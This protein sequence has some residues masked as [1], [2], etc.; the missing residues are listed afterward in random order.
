M[1][2]VQLRPG[3]RTVAFVAYDGVQP[4][5]LDG[6]ERELAKRIF[7]GVEHV[8]AQQRST[9][10]AVCGGRGGKTYTL[11]SLRLVHG[12]LT[13]DLS[14]V[15]PGQ[16]ARAL[17][18]APNDRLRQ[19]SVNYA[20]G[21]MRISPWAQ[22]LVLPKGATPESTVAG[23]AVRRPEG[24]VVTFEAGVASAGGY[25]GRGTSLTDVLFDEFAFFRDSGSV[26]N[27]AVIFRAAAPR[28]LPGG[29]A[30]ATT[31]PWAK[32][33]M[34]YELFARNFG[35]PQ[36]ALVAHAP[37]TV[38]NDDPHIALMVHRERER[39]PD[40]ARRE[41]DAEFMETGTLLFFE[42]A[43]VQT[44]RNVDCP[45]KSPDDLEPGDVVA[46]GG[47]LGFMSDS[48][49]C[50]IVVRRGERYWHVDGIELRPENGRPLEPGAVVERF[51]AL[52]KRWGARYIMTDG[53]YR[54]TLREHLRRHGLLVT[55][56]PHEVSEPYIRV[57]NLLRSGTLS[58]RNDQRLVQ[59]MVEVQGRPRSGGGVSIIHPRW[60][61]GG[62]GDICAAL[63]LAVA[64][65]GSYSVP[66]PAPELGT[67]E[68]EAQQRAARRK[69]FAAEESGRQ[70]AD[71]GPGAH[72]RRTA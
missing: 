15:A 8:T 48:S 18:I 31:T 26:V 64:Q 46:A 29:Q 71:R 63:V 72:W 1:L 3:Q 21:A 66:T 62:H 36:D 6:V 12:I 9:V 53:H 68:W 59:Q 14:T 67:A 34:T 19:E 33:G 17:V 30:I 61:T 37:T 32:T 20:V 11:G 60:A 55:E 35:S 40:N 16:R 22:W 28:V 42:H 65:V 39:D 45:I 5:D 27:D 58:I 49:A 56:S 51:A 41:F 69:R 23:F 25:G 70:H 57:R 38:L 10:L 50:E 2:G 54:E 43:S 47:D 44:A 13:R 24:K 7:G 52:M 4:C